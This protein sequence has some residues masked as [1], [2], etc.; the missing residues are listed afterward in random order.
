MILFCETKLNNANIGRQVANSG[1]PSA[2]EQGGA[3]IGKIVKTGII[4][5]SVDS[6]QNGLSHMFLSKVG[7]KL[8]S[9]KI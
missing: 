7:L 5:F 8:E 9:T 3:K 6:L 4:P 1:L 2:P